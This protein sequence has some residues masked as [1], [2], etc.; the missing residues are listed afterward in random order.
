MRPDGRA[1]PVTNW[2]NGPDG[3]SKGLVRTRINRKTGFANDQLEIVIPAI[4][5]F[6]HPFRDG[7]AKACMGCKLVSDG[8]H[9]W[10]SGGRDICIDKQGQDKPLSQCN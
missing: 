6:S 2:D 7:R 5:D 8:E 10:Y 3:F 1:L 9:S 4:Y